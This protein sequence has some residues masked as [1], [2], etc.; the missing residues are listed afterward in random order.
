MSKGGR[1]DTVGRFGVRSGYV[2]GYAR[3]TLVKGAV[4]TGGLCQGGGRHD[5]VGTIRVRQGYARG[6]LV[7]GYDRAPP[8]LSN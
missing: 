4:L 7:K 1:R 5:M 6:T 2:R 3:G 8:L